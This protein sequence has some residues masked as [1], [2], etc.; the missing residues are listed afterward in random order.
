[1]FNHPTSQEDEGIMKVV[2][3]F[4]LLDAVPTLV[5]AWKFITEKNIEKTWDGIWPQ[6]VSDEDI[7]LVDLK[8][9]LSD[10]SEKELSGWKIFG[11]LLD[12]M[13]YF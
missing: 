1:M 13:V 10:L 8:K 5:S 9:R 4:N 12:W 3:K 7:S 11:I 6:L 2:K